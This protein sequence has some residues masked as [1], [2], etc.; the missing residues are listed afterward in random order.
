LRQAAPFRKEKAIHRQNN[1][2]EKADKEKADN[3]ELMKRENF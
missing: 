1:K 2:K 3:E